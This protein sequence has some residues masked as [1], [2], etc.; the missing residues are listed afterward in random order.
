[1][2]LVGTVACLEGKELAFTFDVTPSWRVPPSVSAEQAA[3][4]AVVLR[5]ASV[6]F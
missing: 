2:T 1:L 3:A 4:T 5:R 6:V